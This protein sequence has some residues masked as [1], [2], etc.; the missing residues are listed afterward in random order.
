LL[1]LLLTVQMF[2]PVHGYCGGFKKECETCTNKRFK[3]SGSLLAALTNVAEKKN[4]AKCLQLADCVSFNF[5]AGTKECE[6][7]NATTNAL[8][9]DAGWDYFKKV[10]F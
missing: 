7:N 10:S 5:N 1:T 9:T 8:N 4:C 6:L 2:S 3:N